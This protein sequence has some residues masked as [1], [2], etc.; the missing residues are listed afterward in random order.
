MSNDT[1]KRLCKDVNDLIIL[2]ED[3]KKWVS[4]AKGM[5]VL[6]DAVLKTASQKIAR[7]DDELK[8]YLAPIEGTPRVIRHEDKFYTWAEHGNFTWNGLRIID[9][10]D[11]F[12][13]DLEGGGFTL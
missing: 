1:D 10:E 7:I 4:E 6:N 11:S 3:I 8:K 2:R 12:Y 13:V 9:I 5:G